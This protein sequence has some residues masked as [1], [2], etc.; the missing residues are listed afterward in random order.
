MN[1]SFNTRIWT[2]Y[3]YRLSNI[4]YAWQRIL[5]TKIAAGHLV[6]WAEIMERN[7]CTVELHSI[8]DVSAVKIGINANKCRR[9]QNAQQFS[10]VL[11][12]SPKKTK[13][14]VRTEESELFYLHLRC[15]SSYSK[16]KIVFRIWNIHSIYLNGCKN[17]REIPL[18]LTWMSVQ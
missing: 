3:T 9:F 14:F 1:N 2:N 15:C 18:N 5:D 7:H 16:S 8:L 10:V 12:I 4:L 13:S 17:I 6:W 11:Q